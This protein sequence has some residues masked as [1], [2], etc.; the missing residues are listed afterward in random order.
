MG[1]IEIPL[2]E[3]QGMKKKIKDLESALNSVSK[4]TAKYKDIIGK[5]ES[6]IYDL[7]NEGFLSRLFHWKSITKPFVELLENDIKNINGT[8]E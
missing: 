7:S 8:S 6:L 1:R 4:E 5:L 3:Y 2:A